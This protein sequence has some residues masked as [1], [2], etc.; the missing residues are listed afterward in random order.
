[1]K[2]M[3]NFLENTSIFELYSRLTTEHISQIL[4]ASIVQEISELKRHANP[5]LVFELL[6]ASIF[7]DDNLFAKSKQRQVL[8][9]FLR[10]ALT[11]ASTIYS[12]D[13]F[14]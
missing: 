4:D 6:I 1:M 2:N 13:S 11:H 12:D 3:L 14:Q 7:T 10:H 8:D 9:R 5:E